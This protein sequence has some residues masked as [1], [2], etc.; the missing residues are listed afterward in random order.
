MLAWRRCRAHCPQKVS[1]MTAMS[2]LRE[3]GDLLEEAAAQEGTRDRDQSHVLLRGQERRRARRV[4]ATRPRRRPETLLGRC[5]FDASAIPGDVRSLE[6]RV[7]PPNP[8]TLI[9]HDVLP[10]RCGACI[11]AP[12]R[13]VAQLGRALR[14]GRR[15]RGFESRHPD[16]SSTLTGPVGIDRSSRVPEETA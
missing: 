14:S 9:F 11:I 8:Y 3:T 5:R 1:S 10:S 2:T 6:L 12:R 15:G 7:D 13:D 4:R 16:H